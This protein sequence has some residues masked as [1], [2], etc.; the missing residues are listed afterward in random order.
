[1]TAM[2]HAPDRPGFLPRLSAHHLPRPRLTASLLESSARVRLIC[3]PA[4]SGKSTLLSECLLQAPAECTVCWLPLAGLS[5]SVAAFCERLAQSLGGA[6]ADESSLLNELARRSSPVWVFLDDYCRVEEPALDALLDRMLALASPAVTWWIGT[7]RRPQCNWPRLLLDDALYECESAALALSRGEIAQ[8]LRHL[9]PARVDDVAGR[10]LQR[11]GGW[12]A[13]VR[14]LLM[15]KCDWLQKTLPQ[16]RMDTLLDYLQHE[17]FNGLSPELAEAWRVLAHL[18]RFNASLCDHLFGAGEG[19]Q[20]MRTL[21][22]LGC[23]IEP[24]QGSPDWLQVCAPLSRLMRGEPWSAGRSWHRRACQWFAAGQ[25]WKCAFEQAL[26][27]EEYEVAVSLL[28]HFSFEHLFEEQTVV[29]LLRLYEQHGEELLLGSA[30]LVGLITAALLFAGRFAQAADCIGQLARF[31]PPR[32]A[33]Q[34]RQL[35]ARWQAQQGWLLHLQGHMDEARE[36]FEQALNELSPQAWTARLLCLSG[37]TQQALLCG[38]LDIAHSINREAL[39]L[40]RAEGSLLFE[41]LLELDHAQ[42]LEQRGVSARAEELLANLCEMLA[43]SVERPTPLLGRI[44]LRRGRLALSMGQQGRAA[45]FFQQGLD[46]CLRSFD[47]RVL[48]GFLGQAQL[49]ADQGDYSQAFMRLRDAE[50]LMQQR[51]IP[52]TVYRGVLL[53]VSSEFWLQQGRPELAREALSR[54]LRHYRGPCARQAP[55][56]TL[57]LIPRIECLLILAE[58]RLGQTQQPMTHLQRLLEHAHANRMVVLEAELLLVMS[59]V[60]WKLDDLESARGYFDNGRTL[61]DHFNLQRL[62]MKFDQKALNLWPGS[63]LAASLADDGDNEGS[64]SL[65]ES[66]VLGLIASGSSNQQI[67]DTLFIS[68]HTVKTHVRRI[69]AKL[70]VERRTHAVA[71]ARMLGLCR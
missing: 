59:E 52:D 39:C 20:W 49:A 22:T 6:T 65:R 67:A 50:R 9:P 14:I 63:T 17:L 51:Q 10:I 5:M 1:M 12:C 54:V 29:L 23:F 46:D 24:W 60:A 42:L 61:A 64:L 32:S 66:Q 36:H 70:G 16:Q 21:Q 38:E 34:Q 57:E 48:Y 41:A 11:S 68:L 56:A 69:H 62:S 15:Q 19:A 27:A 55:P 13:G 18:P 33:E 58:M 47:K 35:I 40:A 37:R 53:Q 8:L 4:G 25:H 43:S 26:L 7:R 3:A 2:T 31:L 44:A 45:E 28:Q 71:R 30:Q